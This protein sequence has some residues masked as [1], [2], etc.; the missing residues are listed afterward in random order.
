MTVKPAPS[1]SASTAMRPTWGM[2]NRGT[3]TLPPSSTA[4]AVVA[5]VSA[6]SN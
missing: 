3:D 5:S 1:G 2:S 4:L 6:T